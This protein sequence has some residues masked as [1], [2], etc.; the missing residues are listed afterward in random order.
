MRDT[1]LMQFCHWVGSCGVTVAGHT[2]PFETSFNLEVD[3]EGIVQVA[4]GRLLI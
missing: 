3:F 2:S 4:L 1:K